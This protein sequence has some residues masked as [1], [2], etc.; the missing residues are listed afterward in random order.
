MENRRVPPLQ[1]EISVYDNEVELLHGLRNGETDAC[2]CMF[3]YFAPQIY[4]RALR[5]VGDADEAEGVL[6]M[7]FIR[8]CEKVE[9]F[10][11]R[12]SLATW[13]YRIATNEALMR[14]RKRKP[15][16][17]IDEVADTISAGDLPPQMQAWPENPSLTVLDAELR[18]HLEAALQ[19]LPESLRVVFVLRELDGLS[20]EETAELLNLGQSAVKVRLHRARLRLRELLDSYMRG[21]EA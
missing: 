17:S 20:T 21:P 10:E 15:S 6:Q 18:E 19:Q 4:A 11:G 8:A 12:S 13:L 3:K 14:L 5:L 1:I 9:E 2:T 16:S 7:T